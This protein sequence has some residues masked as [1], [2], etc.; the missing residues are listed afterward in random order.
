[1]TEGGR[2]DL[3][4]EDARV[5]LYP[6]LLAPGDA[7]RLLA[8]LLE[9]IAWRQESV[10]VFGR[11]VAQPRL[12]AWH[13]DPG[14]TYEYSGLALSP[15]AWTPEL[16]EVLAH[17][18]RARPGARFNSVLLNLYRDGRDSVGWHADD[19]R[20]LGAEPEIA[21]VSL[22]AVRTLQLRHRTRADVARVDLELPHGSALWMWG[23]TQRCWQ[24]RLP[25][26]TAVTAPRVN[27]TFRFILG[28]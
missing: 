2:V 16:L 26:S 5:A 9:R 6:S 28:K 1:M 10:R 25:K 17:L 18:E 23:P 11:A 14:C 3:D 7:D 24:H 13:G 4:L 21:S 12:I 27:L 22:G 8:A 20:S 19:E 15:A